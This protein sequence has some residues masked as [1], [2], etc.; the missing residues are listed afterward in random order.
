MNSDVIV[1]GA[2]PA[3][4]TAAKFLAERGHDVLI[5][6]KDRLPR[7]K[8]CGGGV[9]RHALRFEYLRDFIEE[10]HV[11]ACRAHRSYD[12]T[13]RYFVE[14]HT[15]E[16]LFYNVRRRD[17]DHRLVR[18]AME[19]GAH[20]QE[21][22]MVTGVGLDDGGVR[23][24]TRDSD[25]TAR[26]VIGAGGVLDPVARYIR[27]SE[28]LP[29]DMSDLSFVPVEEYP[30]DQSFID[31]VY[32]DYM[33]VFHHGFEGSVYGWVFPKRGLLNIGIWPRPGERTDVKAVLQ[34]YIDH[35]AG[36]GMVPEA[37]QVERPLGAPLPSAGPAE[38]SV[39]HR[40]VICGDAARMV[41]PLTGEGIYYAMESGR[42]AALTIDE[43]LARGEPTAGRL[44]PYHEMWWS[45][46]G[47]DLR[48]MQ[49]YARQVARYGTTLIRLAQ[50]DRYLRGLFANLFM[51]TVDATGMRG[52]V[53]ARMAIDLPLDV[54]RALNPLKVL[55][56]R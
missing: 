48:A 14:Y 12:A 33:S 11:G 26:V 36:E 7:N 55:R 20:L 56:R 19:A 1:V 9:V 45:T 27:R 4:S 5:L 54:I 30:V 44:A 16:V 51:G 28:G 21:D 31:D 46:F 43:A 23:V 34:G 10:N 29:E 8:A 41:S 6:E 40:M 24:R 39:S 22:T 17:F 32:P 52:R 53:L 13:L 35:L 49:Y 37:T 47:E 25:L 38:V 15:D 3:G 50:K 2:G 18:F 42:M